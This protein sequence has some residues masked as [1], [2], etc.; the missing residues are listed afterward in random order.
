MPHRVRSPLLGIAWRGRWF[1]KSARYQAR[2]RFVS[3][4]NTQR[5]RASEVGDK[6]G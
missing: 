4:L 1:Y 6:G 2:I 5:G 3:Y